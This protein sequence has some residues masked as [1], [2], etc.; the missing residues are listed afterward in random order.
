MIEDALISIEMA[1]GNGIVQIEK[2]EDDHSDEENNTENG[3]EDGHQNMTRFETRW[4]V[5]FLGR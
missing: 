3:D 1:G 2:I 5:E 4:R